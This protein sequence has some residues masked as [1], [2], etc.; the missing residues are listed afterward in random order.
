MSKVPAPQRAGAAARLASPLLAG[1]LAVGLAFLSQAWG[2]LRQDPAAAASALLSGAA[3]MGLLCL[4]LRRPAL[5]ALAQDPDAVFWAGLLAGLALFVVLVWVQQSA[6]VGGR[7]WFWLEDDAMVSMRYAARLAAG[8]GLTWTDGAR[9]EGYSNFAWT[10]AMALVH[11]IGVPQAQASACVLALNAACLAWLACGVRRCAVRFGAG[12]MEAALAGLACALSYDLVDGALSGLEMAAV[13]AVTAASL[14]QGLDAEAEGLDW[15]WT[16]YAL[17]GCLPLLRADG[18]LPAGLLLLAGLRRRERRDQGRQA[19]GGWTAAVAATALALGPGL[20]HEAFRVAYYGQWAPNT[21]TLKA[22]GWP[23]KY[24]DGAFK[25]AHDLARY[26]LVLMAALAGMRVPAW[27]PWLLGLLALAA[28][29]AWTGADYYFFLRFFAAG[30]PLLFA[31][32]FASASRAAQSR[33]L[34]TAAAGALLLL[35]SANA[36]WAFP[37]LLGSGWEAAQERLQVAL[38]MK[39]SVPAG[40]SVASS[41]AGSFFYFSGLPGVDLLGKCDPVVAR[42]RPDPSLGG[43]GHN[44]MDLGHSLGQLKPAW[45]LIQVP[46]WSAADRAYLIPAWDQRLAAHPL[47]LLHCDA[48][49]RQ[50]SDHW[51]LCRC[52][53]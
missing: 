4:A 3:C 30:F 34:P 41:W 19:W 43:C 48:G 8:Q 44:K 40:D 29:C 27:R 33:R 25:V 35:A 6:L 7:R 36:A 16:A 50:I 32:A 15:P 23:G 45:V 39:R 18:A 53:W 14:A 5:R 20:L 31:L 10:L 49:M 46:S 26:P 13:A 1:L 47:F 52:R 22:D 21:Y 24:A 38:Q 17:A 2:L 28:Y 11:R 12:A 42:A 37:A 51:A 9:V